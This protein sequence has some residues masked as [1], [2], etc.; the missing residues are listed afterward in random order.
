MVIKAATCAAGLGLLLALSGP[1]ALAAPIQGTP[2]DAGVV[3]R[4]QVLYWLLKRG[5]LAADASD[6]EKQAAVAAFLARSAKPQAKGNRIEVAYEQ[7]RFKQ[8]AKPKAA[9]AQ[10]LNA[11]A[12]SEI[13]KTVR[14]LG[15]LVDFPDLPHDDNRL[16]AADTRM[17]YPDYPA[18]HY[19]GLL[20]SG[21][22]FSGPSGETL[23]SGY[24][25]YQAASGQTF[26]FTGEV[27]DWVRA[28]NPA[29][30]YGGNDPANDDS[31]KAAQ[32]L[33]LEAVTKVVAGMSDSEIGSFDVEDPYDI[34]NDGNL[35]EPDGVIDHV[36]VFHS[37]VGEEA[38]GG[39]LGSDAIWSHRFVVGNTP[40]SIPGRSIKLFGYTIQPIDA[41]AGVCTHEFGHDLGLP[42]EYDTSY[43]GKGSPVGSWS[44]MSGGSWTGAIPG[45]EPSGFSPFARS[46]L[47]QKYKGKWVNEQEIPLASLNGSSMDL[48]LNQAVDSDGVNQLSIPIPA[49]NILL[50]APY[51]GSFQYYSGQGNLLNN[52]MSVEL[53][54]PSLSPLTL[55][56]KA[57]WDIEE[58][59][60]YMQLLVDGVALPGNHTKASN[61]QNAAR[62]II[63]GASAKLAEAEAPGA[64]VELEYDLSAYAGR[65][66]TLGIKYQTDEASGGYGMAID[67][68]L[69]SNGTEPVYG[70]DA[71]T[72]DKM[73]LVGFSRIGDSFPGKARRYLVQLRSYQGID[74]GLEGEGYEPG[75]L[76][77]LEDLSYSDN[78][79]SEHP[80]HGLIGVVDADQHLI[81]T[82]STDVQVRDAALSMNDQSPY[83]G[84]TNLSAVS[85]FDDSLDYSAPA[86][87]ESG[88]QLTELGLTMQVIAQEVDNSSATLRVARLTPVGEIEPLVANIVVQQLAGKVDFS[89][90]SSGGNGGNSY[91]WDFG[92]PGA[93]STLASPSYTYSDSGSYQVTLVVTDAKGL[94]ATAAVTLNIA[95]PPSAAFTQQVSGLSVNFSNAS[96]AGVGSLVYHWNFGDGQS[97]ELASPSH[98]YSAGGTYTVTLTVSD[99]QNNVSSASTQLSLVAP[100]APAGSGGGGSLGALSLSLLALLGWQRRRSLG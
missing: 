47:Q 25:Y 78:T 33:V 38:G 32:E 4:E 60:D 30:Y 81:G 35:D 77:W 86:Q 5:E 34:D 70:D 93:D 68:L 61:T 40:V 6:E 98:S 89:V 94:K 42:D 41:A 92:V 83:S 85:L 59:Y 88:M 54:L 9:R 1:A 44:L 50:G 27:R 17:Y 23:L 19:Q 91:L 48:A 52:A 39:V 57:R 56:M 37:S 51:E 97:S 62:N 36:M 80:G 31:D 49:G 90:Q 11:L 65:T 82:A 18:T 14:V 69:I 12:D 75:V 43:G 63:T 100:A 84:D 26:S 10:A 64:W 95:I 13:H 45:S 58:D 87:A 24:Q 16:S 76:I 20:F 7:Q 21:T 96:T 29:A 79:V 72:G 28:D 71:E 67:K 73:T 66:V 99:S 3:D 74:S 8:A 15:V 55:T 53:T 22:G 46:Y 2:A